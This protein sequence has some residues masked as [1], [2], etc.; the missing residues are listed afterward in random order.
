V[1]GGGVFVLHGRR[2]L[3]HLS[4]L[5]LV[6]PLSLVEIEPR[7]YRSYIIMRKSVFQISNANAH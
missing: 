3:R 4:D 1:H 6:I 7:P 5:V 2:S